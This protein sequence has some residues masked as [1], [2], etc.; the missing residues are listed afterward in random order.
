MVARFHDTAATLCERHGQSFKLIFVLLFIL[1]SLTTMA[2]ASIPDPDPHVCSSSYFGDGY[3]TSSPRRG[4][5]E[6]CSDTGT[7]RFVTND[8]NDFVSG[9][10]V[11]TET[12]VAVGGGNATSPGYGT[13]IIKSMDTGLSIQCNNVLL[14][15]KCSNKLMPASTFIKKGCTLTFDDYDKVALCDKNN[16]PILNGREI[17]G[18][19]YYHAVTILH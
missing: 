15:P 5:Y 16:D 4:N 12:V 7:N 14:M 17:N 2:G 1:G 19:Y 3:A 6:W 8:T 10:F 13:V 9:T 11:P 18:F